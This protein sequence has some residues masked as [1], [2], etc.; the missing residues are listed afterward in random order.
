MGRNRI[1]QE[2]DIGK[3]YKNLIFRTTTTKTKI[4]IKINK[5]SQK[6]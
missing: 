5:K 6:F 1:L 2:F 3:L 4:S